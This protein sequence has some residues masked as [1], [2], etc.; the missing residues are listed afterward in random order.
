MENIIIVA[1][2][3]VIVNNGR[4]LIVK[5]TDYDEVGPETWECLGGKIEF[6]EELEAAL[7]REVMEEAGL[8]VTVEKLLY[9]TTFK[10]APTR[11]VVVLTYL[12]RS[13]V[14]DVKL[15]T[16]HSDYLW[17]TKDQ[18]KQFLYSGILMDFEKYNVFSIE[19]LL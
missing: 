12:C 3:G 8:D 18:L 2:K 4:V 9:A 5:R 7:I 15:S 13:A 1:V 14:T 19:D 11:Q 10:T 17:A 16:E 6:G